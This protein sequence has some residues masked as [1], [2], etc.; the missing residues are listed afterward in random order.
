MIVIVLLFFVMDKIDE[1]I[2]RNQ[3]AV[4]SKENKE[5]RSISIACENPIMVGSIVDAMEKVS[6]SNEEVS[7]YLYTGS[8]TDILSGIKNDSIDMAILREMTGR[9]IEDRDESDEEDYKCI[10]VPLMPAAIAVRE[11]AMTVQPLQME[12]AQIHILWK[13]KEI[14]KVQ[15]DFL[16]Y[17]RLDNSQGLDNV[18]RK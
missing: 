14:S 1:F 16:T 18:V 15:K 13:N 3:I 10:S 12:A 17:L 5:K 11:I 6:K 9:S 2:E 8:K 7:F 4:N